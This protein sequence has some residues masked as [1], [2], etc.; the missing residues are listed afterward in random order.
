MISEFLLEKLSRLYA[1]DFRKAKFEVIFRFLP[2]FLVII[3]ILPIRKL[4][5]EILCLDQ[6]LN[7]NLTFLI[8]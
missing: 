7:L 3:L 5:P 8:I 1:P 4:S 6:H 2:Q